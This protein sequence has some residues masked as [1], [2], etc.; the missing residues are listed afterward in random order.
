MVLAV[1]AGSMWATADASTCE[2][3]G[4]GRS[5]VASAII[6]GCPEAV[7][8]DA[9]VPDNSRPVTDDRMT[10]PAAAQTS[11]RPDAGPC[12]CCSGPLVAPACTTGLPVP[13]SL[14]VPAATTVPD[15]SDPPVHV[16]P[17]ERR[18]ALHSPRRH[19]AAPKIVP[20]GD[21]D[22]DGTSDDT[23]DDD[24]TSKSLNSEDNTD[25]SIIAYVQEKVSYLITLRCERVA[26][27][28][29][30]SSPFLAPQRLRC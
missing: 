6:G 28:A 21:P 13:E 19:R 17:P 1:I 7:T 30:S 4:E 2:T 18:A 10:V 16:A 12:V 20:W 3:M 26:W 14:P 5:D 29:P 22:D 9:P 8:D 23:D 15:V 24:D 11:S 27:T 25:V